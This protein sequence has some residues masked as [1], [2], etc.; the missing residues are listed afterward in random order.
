[1]NKNSLVS[2]CL[3]DD[4]NQL[5]PFWSIFNLSDTDFFK[6]DYFVNKIVSIDVF[7]HSHVIQLTATNKQINKNKTFNCALHF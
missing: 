1:M 2:I 6:S 4:F 7:H 3:Q 5:M